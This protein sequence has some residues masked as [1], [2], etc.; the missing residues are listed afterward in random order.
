LINTPGTT[1]I[2]QS[3]IR[4]SVPEETPVLSSAE[5]ERDVSGVEPA[6]ENKFWID[7]PA[8]EML[9]GEP[10]MLSPPA[11]TNLL[12]ARLITA[13][14]VASTQQQQPNVEDAKTTGTSSGPILVTPHGWQHVV[15]TELIDDPML[16]N[17][18][19]KHFQDTFKDLYKF[20]MVWLLLDIITCFRCIML[21]FADLLLFLSR[22][23]P[24]NL[25]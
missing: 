24:T 1:T 12:E 15:P 17:K 13:G 16:T 18:K 2:V 5:A 10:I 8:P 11:S 19:L 14:E 9:T 23:W 6:K 7:E 3:V 22:G 25:D 20:S 4:S 21:S